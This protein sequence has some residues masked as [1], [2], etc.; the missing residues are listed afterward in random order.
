MKKLYTVVTDT[1]RNDYE[2]P[3][4]DMFLEE[5]FEEAKECLIHD[6]ISRGYRSHIRV[7]EIPDDIIDLGED[8]DSDRAFSIMLGSEPI[9]FI[10]PKYAAKFQNT[11][12]RWESFLVTDEWFDDIIDDPV[13]VKAALENH[14]YTRPGTVTI[15]PMVD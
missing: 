1:D 3:E 10:F 4:Y 5:E 8:D 14:K 13:E 9:D 6:W 11:S 12:G 7:H 2:F 15:I